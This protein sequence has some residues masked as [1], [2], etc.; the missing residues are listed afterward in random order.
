MANLATVA[1]TEDTSVLF[2]EATVG[3]VGAAT[4][5]TSMLFSLSV[6]DVA[7]PVEARG[8]PSG[9]FTEYPPPAGLNF[10]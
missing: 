8:H 9:I 3:W 2:T 1:F 5:A 4:A 10:T 7:L 6:N